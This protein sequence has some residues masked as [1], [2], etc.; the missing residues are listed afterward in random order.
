MTRYER[1][2]QILDQAIGG[3]GAD[4]GAHGAFWRGLTRDQF[5]AKPVFNNQLLVVGNGAA[6]NLVKAFKGEAPFGADLPSPPPGA[7]YPRMPDG[8]APVSDADIAFIETW[9]DEG[10]LEDPDPATTA[11]AAR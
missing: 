6:S 7:K 2:Q 9:I 11:A 8:F 4:I 1:V 5:V 3:P 10:C